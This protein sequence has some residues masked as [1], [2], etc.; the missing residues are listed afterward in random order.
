MAQHRIGRLIERQHQIQSGFGGGDLGVLQFHVE[1]LENSWRYWRSS[2]VV[3][4]VKRHIDSTFEGAE[5]LFLYKLVMVMSRLDAPWQLIRLATKAAGSD[6]PV[7]ICETPY[8]VAIDIVFAEIERRVGEL[9]SELRT[10]RGLAT[11]ALLKSIHDA[12]RGIRTEIDLEH[13]SPWS[14][15][16]A[17]LRTEV[18]DVLRGEIESLNGRVRRLI[19]PRPTKEIAPNSVVDQNDLEDAESQIEFVGACRTYAGELALNE[20]T[21][22]TWSEL[23]LYLDSATNALVDS[24]RLAS[25]PDRS[26]RESQFNAAMRFCGKVFGEE[27]AQVLVKARDSAIAG[28]RKVAAKA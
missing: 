13:D 3:G 15:R 18:S 24:L 26:F 21:S 6:N 7:R 19:R 11:G 16:L 17:A 9:K 25:P 28:E 5:R 8:S 10:G 23:E 12:A 27:Y 14:R 4:D 2:P 20:L 1:Y 22:R